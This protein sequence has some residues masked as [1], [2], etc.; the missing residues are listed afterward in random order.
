MQLFFAI[1]LDFSIV[2]KLM[3]FHS[4]VELNAQLFNA[5]K[6]PASNYHITLSYLG[7]TN[8]NNLDLILTNLTAPQIEPFEITLNELFY[9]QKQN[10]VGL[11]IVD[12]DQTYQ[13]KSSI[14]KQLVSQGINHFDRKTF[15]PHLTLFRNAE[16]A[17]I[18]NPTFNQ[19]M[20][21]K[22]FN[23]IHSEQPK[24][25]YKKA[26][27]SKYHTIETWRLRSPKSIKE[28]LTGISKP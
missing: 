16:N 18:I 17:P 26:L 5:K 22:T 13:L 6:I 14:E 27:H 11:N 23:L 20:V 4:S 2:S 12:S 3:D 24:N 7:K 28:Q 19:S 8:D 9:W 21:V 15:K 25:H 10:I 1:E